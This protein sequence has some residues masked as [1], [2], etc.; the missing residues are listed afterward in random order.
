MARHSNSTYTNVELHSYF[1]R[2]KC[3]QFKNSLRWFFSRSLNAV[4]LANGFDHAMLQLYKN[5]VI[6]SISQ[7]HVELRQLE[8]DYYINNFWTLS[9]QSAL[10]AG[11]AFAQLTTRLPSNV[12]LEIEAPYLILTVASLTLHLSVLISTIFCCVWGPGLAL[13]GTCVSIG[14]CLL[15]EGR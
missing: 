4:F 9:Q 3:S 6:T 14:K 11:F 2:T 12:S 15:V 1:I 10:L 5:Q 13:R 7:R 8:L